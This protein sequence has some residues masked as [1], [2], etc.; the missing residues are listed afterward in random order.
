MKYDTKLETYKDNIRELARPNRFAITLLFPTAVNTPV[1][2]SKN[3][4]LCS[5]L[6]QSASIPD[7]SFNEIEMKYYGM[8]YKFPGG[9]IVQDLTLSFYNDANF[10]MRDMFEQWANLVNNR[11]T[12]VKASLNELFSNGTL[13]V[14]QLS[15]NNSK[16]ATYEFVN[17][18]PKTV[19]Q[20]ELSMENYDTV[21]TFQVVF[22]YSYFRSSLFPKEKDATGAGGFISGIKNGVDNIRNFVGF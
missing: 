8:S 10:E 9:E 16:V 15:G 13:Q 4:P 3:N 5:F 21:E 22:G 11:K 17:P 12:S 18:Y 20:I 2:F 7:R 6:L 1:D 19:D 14:H